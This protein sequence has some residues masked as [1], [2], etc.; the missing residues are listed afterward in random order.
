MGANEPL[1]GREFVESL[2]SWPALFRLLAAS[3]VGTV[4]VG[5]QVVSAAQ[6]SIR[7]AAHASWE[8][9]TAA[10]V[11]WEL[12]DP[13]PSVFGP[14]PFPSGRLPRADPSSRVALAHAGQWMDLGRLAL[15]PDA[16]VG[17]PA[18]LGVSAIL[19]GQSHSLYLPAAESQA[20]YILNQAPRSSNV[21]ISRPGDVAQL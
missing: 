1:A 11:S 21:A 17:G 14:N 4:D 7:L 6:A 12:Y 2:C 5:S 3:P 20:D 19:L 16:A 8:W 13:Q 9:R 18:S 10:E 15:V